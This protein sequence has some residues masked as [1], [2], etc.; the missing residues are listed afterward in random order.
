MKTV[1]FYT[2]EEVKTPVVEFLNSLTAK[3]A[4]KVT[5]VLQLVEELDVI[6]STDLKKLV[7]T[8]DIWEVRAQ[9]GNN[10]LG[11]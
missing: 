6:P 8:E 11:Y 7:D 10:I 5:W 1:N 9:V 3:Q 4:Q 2:T